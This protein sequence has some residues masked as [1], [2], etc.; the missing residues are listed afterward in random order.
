ME[1][2]YTLYN[3]PPSLTIEEMLR[4]VAVGGA[5]DSKASV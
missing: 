1:Y 3:I 5:S 4:N 2:A